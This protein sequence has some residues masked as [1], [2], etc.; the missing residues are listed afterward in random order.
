MGSRHPCNCI[1]ALLSNQP[2]PPQV[3]ALPDRPS[4]ASDASGEPFSTRAGCPVDDLSGRGSSPRRF[5]T[6]PSGL[7]RVAA[8]CTDRAVHRCPMSPGVDSLSS[9]LQAAWSAE[10]LTGWDETEAV[11]LQSLQRM[12][13]RERRQHANSRSSSGSESTQQHHTA[14]TAPASTPHAAAAAAA[15]PHSRSAAVQRRRSNQEKADPPLLP[16]QRSIDLTR[17]RRRRCDKDC[18]TRC[19]HCPSTVPPTVLALSVQASLDPSC[20]VSC[21]ACTRLREEGLR[22]TCPRTPPSVNRMQPRI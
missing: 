2:A 1:V 16:A 19:H 9:V 21:V 4:Y 14:H 15:P 13:Q 18:V 3:S 10:F 17:D 8:P 22:R 5:S 7:S 12:H 6:M 11:R 20:R